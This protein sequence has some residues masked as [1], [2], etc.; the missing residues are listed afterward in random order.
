M[1][2][3]LREL[4]AQVEQYEFVYCNMAHEDYRRDA[5]GL[6]LVT[7]DAPG[8]FVPECCN[9]IQAKRLVCPHSTDKSRKPFSDLIQFMAKARLLDEP[10]M[11]SRSQ[12]YYDEDL[13]RLDELD[14]EIR[15][16]RTN[17]RV[18]AITAQ[19][20]AAPLVEEHRQIIDRI[21]ALRDDLVQIAKEHLAQTALP[22]AE[23]PS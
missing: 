19:K 13:G 14:R 15:E 18:D 17:G 9:E 8:P 10:I 21:K 23:I 4:V 5:H 6:P 22:V 7:I 2:E 11:I 1:S 12:Y 16:A 20:R 3:Q